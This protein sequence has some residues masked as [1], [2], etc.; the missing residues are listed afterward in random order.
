MFEAQ[1]NQIPQNPPRAELLPGLRIASV[2]PRAALLLPFFFFIIFFATVPLSVMH[3]DP[4]TRLAWGPTKTSQGAVVSSTDTACRGSTARRLIYSFAADHGGEF[5]G[6]ATLCEGALY[7]TAQVGDSVQVQYLTSDP[8]VNV[9]RGTPNNSP[10]LAIFMLMP[11]FLLAIILS[12]F[13]PQV[14]ELLKARALFKRGRLASGEVLFVKK[15]ASSYRTYWPGA[16]SYEVFIEYQS[17]NGCREAVA[18]CANDWLVN[19]L[20]P[21][22][23]VHIAYSEDEPGKAALLEAFLR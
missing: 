22:A 6:S 4:A 19:Q 20:P 5:R 23:K 2:L 1:L 12:M 17:G 14:R 15:R 9:L 3:S 13:L 8:T 21:G 11:L 7:Y 10:P 16:A 18:W